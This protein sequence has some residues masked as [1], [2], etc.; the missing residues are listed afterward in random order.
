MV[1]PATLQGGYACSA[2]PGPFDVVPVND[3]RVFVTDRRVP[4]G[5]GVGLGSFPSLMGMLVVLV[6]DM[7]M[8][9]TKARMDVLGLDRIS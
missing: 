3:Q 1:A 5:M 4:V 7:E 6:M 8:V 2:L 9:V